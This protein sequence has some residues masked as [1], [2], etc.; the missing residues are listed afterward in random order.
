M[1]TLRC[2]AIL[3]DFDGVIVDSTQVV[4]AQYTRWAVEH[5]LD[6][7][8]LVKFAHGVRT[9]EVVRHAAPHLDA[10]EETR[11]IEEREANDASVVVM[12]GAVALLKTLPRDRW[13]IVTSGGRE[14]ATTRIRALHLPEPKVLVTADDVVR[15]KP[16]PL[17]YLEGARLLGLNPKDC[18]VFE[19]APAGIRAAK[20]AGMTV[21]SMPSTY[22][23]EELNEADYLVPGLDP[24]RVRVE[25]GEQPIMVELP[26]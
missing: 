22:P 4:A 9:V 24:V 26:E 19:D 25:D 12:P 23:V 20:G 10:E 1:P 13:G 11:R 16:D 18:V 14:L 2:A 6:A 7:K 21:V 3:F 17:P 8:A 15:G 5:D